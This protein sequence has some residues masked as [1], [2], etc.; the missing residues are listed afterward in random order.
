MPAKCLFQL[1]GQLDETHP[2]R[3][4]DIH[5]YIDVAILSRIPSGPGSEKGKASDWMSMLAIG[6]NLV[7]GIGIVGTP[8]IVR[9]RTSLRDPRDMVFVFAAL[10]AGIAAGV[11]AYV[12]GIAGTV[13]FCLVSFYLKHVAFGSRNHFDGLLRFT[14]SNGPD[15]LFKRRSLSAA[16]LA[17]WKKTLL[18]VEGIPAGISELLFLDGGSA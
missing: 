1:F 3:G 2:N 6:N 13:V 9:F 14:L 16:E 11:G 8:A 4:V 18:R 7:W 5:Q 17:L 10:A 15:Q 12:V